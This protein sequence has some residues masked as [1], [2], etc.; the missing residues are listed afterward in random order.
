MRNI[1]VKLILK[2]VKLA[3]NK[4]LQGSRCG[5]ALDAYL[6]RVHEHVPELVAA[7][8]AAVGGLNRR[9]RVV[10]PM[11]LPMIL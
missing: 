1:Q 4:S 6:P 8:F 3:P 2:G 11:I 7:S 9:G 5:I 10:L